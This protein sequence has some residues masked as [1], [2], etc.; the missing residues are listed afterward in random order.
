MNWLK[1]S[2]VL[3]LVGLLGVVA[4]G[5]IW[6]IT[7]EL[8]SLAQVLGIGGALA[9]VVYAVIDRDTLAAGTS[10]KE[11]MGAASTAM[12]LV[13]A[14]ML[15]VLVYTLVQ[16]VDQTADVTGNGRWSLS[17]RTESVV[18]G[19]D[20]P[21]QIYALFR[22]GAP[23]AERFERI[24]GQYAQ[25]NDQVVYEAIDP[26]L[27]PARARSLVKT[28]GNEDMDR[29]AETG[30]VL[31]H[32]NGR[33]RRLEA[34]FD[35]QALTNAIVKL[36]AG[37]DRRVCWSVGHGE[38]D[39]D[40]DQTAVG[41]GVTVLRLEDRN[42][43]VTEQSMLTSGISRECEALVIAGPTGDFQQSELEALAGYI[44]EGG[45]VLLALD[46]PNPE[47][48][49]VPNLID[50]LDRY[51]I[52]VTDDAILENNPDNVASG[53]GGEPVM[54]YR[55]PN[56]K[57]HPILQGIGG[58]AVEWPRSV[59]ATDTALGIEVRELITSSDR[60][61]AEPQFDILA[62]TLPQPDPG[63][64]LGPIPFAVLAEILDPSVLEVSVEPSQDPAGSDIDTDVELDR[65]APEVPAS[66]NPPTSLL[67]DDLTPKA[68][69]RLMVIG[70]AD[71]A[72]NPLTGLANNG[73]LALNAISFLLG[74]DDQ[75]GVDA[76]DSEYLVLSD[77]QTAGLGLLGGFLIPAFSALAGLVLLLRRRFM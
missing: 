43:V 27:Q 47:G 38:R 70:D 2:W 37:E 36:T 19:I 51:G 28:T 17:T 50:E 72:G 16:R 29:L 8:G 53:P 52:V 20:Q 55:T 5:S 74:E 67:P 49:D 73:D 75:M 24:A 6:Y 26:L 69:G 32:S 34:R 48:V 7:G 59:Q 56:F 54:V 77:G 30:T 35:E 39:A 44:A 12:V 60:S 71:F 4:C 46:S 45:Q 13:L 63:E 3:G 18:D 62:D 66:L 57:A 61:W 33:R 23:D 9:L 14:A 68:G 1:L 64:Q 42:V 76:D 10:A 58:V 22:K 21:V 40:D 15:S 31:L 11:V 25:R 65:S 41:W